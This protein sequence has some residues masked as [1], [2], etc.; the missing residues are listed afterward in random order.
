MMDGGILL[1]LLSRHCWQFPLFHCFCRP[2]APAII[3]QL[4]PIFTTEGNPMKRN[5]KEE[6]FS[7]FLGKAQARSDKERLLRECETLG[8]TPYVN[9]PSESSSEVYAQLRGVA[10]E[11]EQIQ[12]VHVTAHDYK[13]P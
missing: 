3:V 2:L 4:Q 10:S 9:D 5:P 13:R 7:S 12:V 6:D 8:V 1:E 11:A